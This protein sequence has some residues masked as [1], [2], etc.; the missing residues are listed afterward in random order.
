MLSECSHDMCLDVFADLGFFMLI[1]NECAELW[2]YEVQVG[3]ISTLYL[4]LFTS[5]GQ[6]TVVESSQKLIILQLV[7]SN[8]SSYSSRESQNFKYLVMTQLETVE[9]L[10]YYFC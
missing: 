3:N 1:V 4:S 5:T 10:H 9:T 2:F 8:C 6:Q 7:I